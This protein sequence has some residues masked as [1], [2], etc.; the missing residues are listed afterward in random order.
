MAPALA[1]W[2][3]QVA[4]WKEEAAQWVRTR[5]EEHFSSEAG[6]QP[7]TA[8][9][10][11]HM[12]DHDPS[13]PTGWARLVQSESTAYRERYAMVRNTLEVLAR[14]RVL[15]IGSTVNVKGKE[16]TSTYARPRD[17]SA[18]WTIDVEALSSENRSRALQGIK[19]WL[20]LDGGLCLEGVSTIMLERKSGGTIIHDSSK[21]SPRVE[22]SEVPSIKRRRARPPGRRRRPTHDGP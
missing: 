5:I 8:G 2:E 20:A 22:N 9:E 21:N 7:M 13:M 17:A 11:M 15:V 4:H 1:R 3:E 10:V 18:D 19:Q 6:Y 12:L 14:Q 16:N